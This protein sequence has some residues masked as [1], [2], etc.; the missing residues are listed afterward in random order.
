MGSI[1]SPG[2]GSGLDVNNIVKSLVDAERVPFDEKKMQLKSLTQ[3]KYLP[4]AI[5]KVV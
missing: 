4:S 3:L 5:S 2:L 1:S